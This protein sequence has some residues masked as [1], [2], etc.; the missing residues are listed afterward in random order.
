MA[1][2]AEFEL[3]FGSGWRPN[4]GYDGTIYLFSTTGQYSF[5]AVTGLICSTCLTPPGFTITTGQ[6]GLINRI[7]PDGA[8]DVFTAPSLAQGSASGEDVILS[9]ARSRGAEGSI[10][11]IGCQG[12]L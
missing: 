12:E 9:A 10:Y 5:D 4:A 6:D 7:R 2:P 1:G 8:S 3:P 11:A